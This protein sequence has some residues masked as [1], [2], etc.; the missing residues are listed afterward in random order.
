MPARRRPASGR[1]VGFSLLKH[2]SW[3][4]SP[5]L[6]KKTIKAGISLLLLHAKQVGAEEQAVAV[7]VVAVAVVVVAVV[8]AAVVVEAVAAEV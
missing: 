6:S 1:L 2:V 4:V 5:T 3:P 7:A 8:A